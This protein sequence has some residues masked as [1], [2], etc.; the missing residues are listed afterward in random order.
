M[1]HV[2]EEV[3]KGAKV[4]QFLPKVNGGGL[5]KHGKLIKVSMNRLFQIEAR[6]GLLG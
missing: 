1:V 3:T 2:A 5:K 6:Y 4:R